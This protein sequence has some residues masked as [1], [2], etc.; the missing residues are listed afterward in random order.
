[1]HGMRAK[2]L[3]A[4]AF[5]A[6]LFVATHLILSAEVEVK[7]SG[8]DGCLTGHRKLAQDLPCVAF[9]SEVAL[10]LRNREGTFS[11]LI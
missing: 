6:R 5:N 2:T 11:L 10:A 1:M 4:A 9:P 8:R 3:L 7:V